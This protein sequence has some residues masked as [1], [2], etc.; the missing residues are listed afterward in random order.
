[1][2]DAVL[3]GS[4]ASRP[5]HVD[6]ADAGPKIESISIQQVRSEGR[7]KRVVSG[8]GNGDRNGIGIKRRGMKREGQVASMSQFKKM[9]TRI[10]NPANRRENV[11]LTLH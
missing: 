5:K 9:T 10:K 11:T 2:Q 7:R 3:V 8:K 6:T 4:E 1:M